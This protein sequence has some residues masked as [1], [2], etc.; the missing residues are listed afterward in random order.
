MINLAA[1]TDLE[2]C[3]KNL[4]IIWKT[5]ALGAENMALIS[6]KLNAAHVYI[7][8]AGIFDGLKEY[9]NDFD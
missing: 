7:S 2:Y 1:L 5:N 4:E 3:K 9:Y 6:R 8:T